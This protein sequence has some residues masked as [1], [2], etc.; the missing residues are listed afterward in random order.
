MAARL[1]SSPVR[2]DGGQR[3]NGDWDGRRRSPATSYLENGRKGTKIAI[4]ILEV[5]GDNSGRDNQQGWSHNVLCQVRKVFEVM[6]VSVWA[7][8]GRKMIRMGWKC[9]QESLSS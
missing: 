7:A 3:G 8:T 6:I 4:G 9:H 1:G 2:I 5:A